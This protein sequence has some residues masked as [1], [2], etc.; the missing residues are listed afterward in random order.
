MSRPAIAC[1]NT[2][3]GTELPNRLNFF[4]DGAKHILALGLSQSQ[5]LEGFGPGSQKPSSLK[6]KGQQRFLCPPTFAFVTPLPV[7]CGL[8]RVPDTC[9]ALDIQPHLARSYA[10]PS[11]TPHPPVAPL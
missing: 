7:N 2:T 10:Y 5:A 4:F 3:L 11:S 8:D 6:S 9:C 1:P